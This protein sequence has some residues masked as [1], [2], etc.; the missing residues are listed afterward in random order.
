MRHSLSTV[1]LAFALASPSAARAGDLYVTASQSIQ[2]AVNAAVDGDVI[3]VSGTHAEQVMVDK[4]VTLLGAPGATVTSPAALQTLSFIGGYADDGVTPQYQDAA[5]LFTVTAPNATISGFTIDGGSRLAQLPAMDGVAFIRGG[6][7]VIGCTIRGI[8]STD[9]TLPATVDDG[10]DVGGQGILATSDLDAELPPGSVL[11]AADVRYVTVQGCTLTQW[12]AQ[13][14]GAIGIS[15]DAH[16]NIVRVRLTA[17]D[18]VVV[19]AGESNVHPQFGMLAFRGAVGTFRRNRVS[20]MIFTGQRWTSEPCYGLH[21]NFGDTYTVEDN[22]FTNVQIGIHI[23]NINGPVTVS[24]NTVVS[25][26]PPLKSGTAI[27][28]W[29]DDWDNNRKAATVTGNQVTLAPLD[30][31]LA[32]NGPGAIVVNTGQPATIVGNTVSVQLHGPANAS[33]R[34]TPV[35]IQV[36]ADG[37]TIRGNTLTGPGLPSSIGVLLTFSSNCLVSDNA[38]ADFSE[39]IVGYDAALAAN[40][41]DGNTFSNVSQPTAEVT[42]VKN[43]SGSPPGGCGPF[44][45]YCH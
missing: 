33:A 36:F 34:G 6:G 22:T 18:N 1:T 37:H 23:G 7:A 20:D 26:A 13:G 41:L 4:N 45:R 9:R 31:R 43:M 42:G 17:E 5:G 44:A 24:G 35:G 3:H 11:P 14:I 29:S 38:L 21:G 28:L 2:T 8:N 16:S 19:G 12:E 32:F 40:S 27:Y 30:G 39:G 25:A 15:D 10:T